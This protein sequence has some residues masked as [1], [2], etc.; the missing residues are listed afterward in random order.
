MLC[1]VA[2]IQGEQINK[3]LK[4]KKQEIVRST[5]RLLSSNMARTAKNTTLQQF[6]VSARKCLP[7]SYLATKRGIDF[8]EPLPNNDLRDTHRETETDGKI[9]EVR[10]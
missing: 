6:F 8:S 1:S 3:K 4:I 7:S 5:N 10:R 2:K 9:Y